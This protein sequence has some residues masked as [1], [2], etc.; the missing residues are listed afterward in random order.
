MSDDFSWLLAEAAPEDSERR[1][2]WRRLPKP[3]LAE[4]KISDPSLYV[5]A[6][7][8]VDALNA[9]LI[10]G[11]PL[12]LTGEPGCG[13]TEAAHY[14]AWRL[15]L[16]QGSEE[17]GGDAALRFDVKSTTAAKDLFYSFDVI[18]R[19]YAA[20][21]KEDTDPLRFLTLNA[22][23]RA[24]F[25]AD[26][27]QPDEL[28]ALLLDNPGAEPRRAVVLVDEVDKAPRDVPNDLLVEFEKLRFTIPEIE[29]TF[30]ASPDLRPIVVL[31]SNRERDLPDAFLR[32][33]VVFAVPFPKEADLADIVHRRVADVGKSIVEDAVS[34]TL[35]LREANLRRRPGTAE[36]ISF[37]AALKGVGLAHAAS[38]D[39]HPNW[40]QIA[41]TTL[42]KNSHDHDAIGDSAFNKFLT[43]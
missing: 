39:Q 24:I 32:R 42:L 14:L 40:E 8:L 4:R 7:G 17:R 2:W 1:D 6:A 18:R 20:Q 43:G 9:A 10:L 33:C 36:L 35:R 29:R 16:D 25:E 15:G 12:L 11:Q 37:V 21:V 13:K 26:P 19:F 31:T 34:L 41:R 28:R 38:F 3:A 27:K 5:P 22:L 23:G 30:E